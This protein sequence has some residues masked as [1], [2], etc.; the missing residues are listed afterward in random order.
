M[1]AICS[2]RICLYGVIL[3]SCLQK[4]VLKSV[5]FDLFSCNPTDSAVAWGLV[6]PKSV[7]KTHSMAFISVL[8]TSPAICGVT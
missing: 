4:N 5:E 8:Y 6:L 3:W 2:K 1:Q 7:A